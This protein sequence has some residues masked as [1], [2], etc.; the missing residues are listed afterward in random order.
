MN[1]SDDQLRQIYRLRRGSCLD[2]L[3][4]RCQNQ[5]S[6][7]RD[8]GLFQLSTKQELDARQEHRAKSLN[9]GLV[10]DLNPAH[11]LREGLIVRR[12]FGLRAGRHVTNSTEDDY[13]RKLVFV[14][15]IRIVH[16]RN[17]FRGL[18]HVPFLTLDGIVAAPFRVGLSLFDFPW[19]LRESRRESLVQDR[20]R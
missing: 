18:P 9:C 12:R 17:V 10:A 16:P 20:L 19:I 7:R 15:Q 11:Q 2:L 3:N 13:E 1:R 4:G 5:R 14:N 8:C 6:F